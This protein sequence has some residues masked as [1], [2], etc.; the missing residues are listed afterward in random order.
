[1]LAGGTLS[2]AHEVV[3]FEVPV[4]TAGVE[5]KKPK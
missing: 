1:M 4:D 2:T 5:Y 3:H